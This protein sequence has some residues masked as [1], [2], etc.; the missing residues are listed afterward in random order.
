[1]E[2]EELPPLSDD[3]RLAFRVANMT[4]NGMGGLDWSG[5]A[6]LAAWV[7]I[8][9]IDGLLNRL[10]VIVNYRPPKEN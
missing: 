3:D 6:M 1:M 2:S 8:A 7:G 4:R 9:D 10:S 5:V